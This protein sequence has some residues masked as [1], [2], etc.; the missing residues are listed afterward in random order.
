MELYLDIKWWTPR[1]R[2]NP[3]NIEYKKCD[4]KKPVYQDQR[5]EFKEASIT[6]DI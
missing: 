3:Q 5:L 4:P 2:R 1:S 6:D